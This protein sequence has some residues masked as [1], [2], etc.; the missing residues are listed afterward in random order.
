DTRAVQGVPAV[1]QGE[2]PAT[3]PPPFLEAQPDRGA[4]TKEILGAGGAGRSHRS[5]SQTVSL[6]R[7]LARRRAKTLRPPL[8]FILSRNPCVRFR[9]KFECCRIVLD[10]RN[11]PADLVGPALH[12]PAAGDPLQF[13]EQLVPGA[14]STPCAGQSRLLPELYPMPKAHYKKRAGGCQSRG[15][16]N[17]E[18]VPGSLATIPLDR[19][20]CETCAWLP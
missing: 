19:S 2:Q 17:P 7:P 6:C 1:E 14:T 4:V 10:M 18:P 12:G 8:V 11:L 16:A 15:R 13:E 3:Q 9:A 20:A 5:P